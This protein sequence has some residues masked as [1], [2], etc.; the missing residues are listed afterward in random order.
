MAGAG[1]IIYSTRDRDLKFLGLVGPQMFQEKHNGL[2]DIPK[3]TIEP[4]EEALSTALRELE[5]EAGIVLPRDNY[6]FINYAGLTIYLAKS[7]QSAIIKPN[8]VT[9]IIEHQMALYIVPS[10]L[11]KQAYDYLVPAVRWA[12]DYLSK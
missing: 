2:F 6:P 7:E 11:E 8:P 4:G 10:L 5:E 12:R 1:F 3:G 9:G